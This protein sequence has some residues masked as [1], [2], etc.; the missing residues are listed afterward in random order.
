MN[1]RNNEKNIKKSKTIRKLLLIIS[2]NEMQ[3]KI[4]TKNHILINSMT[5]KQL[6]NLFQL[7]KGPISTTIS[8]YTNVLEKHFVQK[9]V[10]IPK[11]IDYYYSDIMDKKKQNAKIFKYQLLQ[12]AKDFIVNY[13]NL[14]ENEEKNCEIDNKEEEIVD[15]LIPFYTKKKSVAH[16]KIKDYKSNPPLEIGQKNLL[17][18]YEDGYKNSI[19]NM[20]IN[21]KTSINNINSY[22]DINEKT[23]DKYK[24]KSEN[25]N[26]IKDINY[27]LVYYCYTYLKRKRPQFKPSSNISIYGLQIEEE[28]LLKRTKSNYIKKRQSKK[29][30]KILDIKCKSSKEITKNNIQKNK[31]KEN[32][33]IKDYKPKIRGKSISNKNRP[34]KSNLYINNNSSVNTNNLGIDPIIIK[35]LTKKLISIKGEKGKTSKVKRFSQNIKENIRAKS[36]IRKSKAHNTN[37]SLKKKAI[38][39]RRS[40]THIISKADTKNTS[41]DYLSSND[42]SSPIKH[43]NKIKIINF[44]IH[45]RKESNN[46]NNSNKKEK[47]YKK[48]I[49]DKENKSFRKK[50]KKTTHSILKYDCPEEMKIKENVHFRKAKKTLNEPIRGKLL[51]SLQK[52]VEFEEKKSF[53]E[54][55]KERNKKYL[56]NKPSSKTALYNKVKAFQEKSQKNIKKFK[57]YDDNNKDDIKYFR[58]RINSSISKSM[59]KLESVELKKI[60]SINKK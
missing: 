21:E 9:I 59:K 22:N 49:F 38:N 12:S 41:L 53:K 13:E 60:N 56:K 52:Y 45:P 42:M 55:S 20:E 3:K 31:K 51:N 40:P 54:K 11:N 17:K 35:T 8:T 28:Y 57:Y 39:I 48:L 2:D 5:P 44:H 23:C 27:K 46:Y 19:N 32:Q 15:N 47:I 25:K 26:K 30:S 36:I 33:T 34:K 7:S 58:H 16:G 37:T 4:K 18:I 10:N 43:K 6:E 29:K 1:Q 14:L 50:T 24:E